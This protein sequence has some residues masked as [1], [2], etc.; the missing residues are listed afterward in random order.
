M[1]HDSWLN[2]HYAAYTLALKE[3]KFAIESVQ[4]ELLW[5]EFAGENS[6]NFS[7]SFI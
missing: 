1:S 6:G 4:F 7:L 5:M 2:S 3:I